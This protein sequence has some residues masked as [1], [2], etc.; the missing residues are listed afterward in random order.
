[1]IQN[2]TKLLQIIFLFIFF[3]SCDNSPKKSSE[4]FVYFD[5]TEG[6]S[7]K[8]KTEYKNSLNEILNYMDL[9]SSSC[10]GYGK[11]KYSFLNYEYFNKPISLKISER[12]DNMNPILQQQK[13][14]EFKNSVVD[15]LCYMLDLPVK[16]VDTLQSII[17]LHILRDIKLLKKSKYNN[18]IMILFSDMM[19]NNSTSHLSF[20]KEDF[21]QEKFEE[22][23]NKISETYKM[24]IPDPSFFS[25]IKIYVIRPDHEKYR[26]KRL[27]Y[28]NFWKYVFGS[29]NCIFES[30]LELNN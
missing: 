23:K 20:I 10:R 2:W 24:N 28:E 19:E 3:Q 21:N 30:E 13:V 1:M 12:T 15:T 26:N 18:K 27:I 25:G 17:I 5:I 14:D 6:M 11:I 9:N 8:T 29:K 22:L 4:V 7:N 16:K